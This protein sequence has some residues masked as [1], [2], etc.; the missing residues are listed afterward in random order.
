M[1]SSQV[2]GISVQFA[3]EVQLRRHQLW[4]E[5]ISVEGASG[6]ARANDLSGLCGVGSELH[7]NPLVTVA[8]DRRSKAMSEFGL[9]NPR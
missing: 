4:F 5:L 1:A 9:E 6:V 2:L 7:T 3:A 8:I